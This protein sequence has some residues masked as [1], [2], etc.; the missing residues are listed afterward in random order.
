MPKEL[1]GR[2]EESKTITEI[3]DDARA[4]AGAVALVEGIIGTGKTSLLRWAEE[5]ARDRGMTVLS[6]TA[7]PAEQRFPLGVVHQLL[8]TLP[9]TADGWDRTFAAYGAP[10]GAGRAEPDY[11]LLAELCA[12]VGRA[13][14]RTPILLTVDSVQHVDCPSLLW[15]GFLSRR[16]E[17]LPVVLLATK[18]CGEPASDQHLLVEFMEGLRPDRHIHLSDLSPSAALDLA[19]S[20][21]GHGHGHEAVDALVAGTGGNPYLLTEQIRTGPTGRSGP[22]LPAGAGHLGGLPGLP[23]LPGR[24]GH[25]V[26]PGY[27]ASPGHPRAPRHLARPADSAEARAGRTPGDPPDERLGLQAVKERI[28]CML[29]R[30]DPYG[31]EIA[32]AASI[33]CGPVDAALLADL[34]GLPTEDACR[35]ISRLTESGLLCP[36]D[37]KFRHPLL[38][39]LLYQDIPCAERAEL[40]RLAARRMRHRGDPGED[41]AA[42]LLRSHRLDEPWMAQLLMEVAQGVVEH[43]PAGARRLVEKAVLHGVPEGHEDRA[44]TLRIQALSGLDLPAAARALTA[45]T[46]TVTAPAERFRHALLLSDLRLRL[47]DTAGA[48]EVLEEARRETAGTLD[49]TSAARLREAMAQVRFHDGG[50]PEAGGHGSGDHGAG[51][52]DDGGT[53]GDTGHHSRHGRHPGEEDRLLRVLLLRTAAGDSAAAAR[54]IADRLLSVPRAPYGSARWYQALLAQLWS[55]DAEEA[56]RHIDTEVGLARTDGSTTRIAEALA[57]RGLVQLHRGQLARAEDDAREA[58]DLLTRIRAGR[59]HVGPLA[60]SVLIDVAMERDDIAAAG[61]L[62]DAA[63]PLPGDRPVTWWRLHLLHSAG[64]ALGRLGEARRGLVLL[65]HCEEELA[66]RGIVNPAILPWRSTRAGLQLARRNVAAARRAAQEETALAH[67]WG[68]P[69]ALGRALVAESAA[70][71]GREALRLADRAVELLEPSPAPLLFAHALYAAGRA[72]RQSG[73]PRRSRELL[74]RANEVGISLGAEG[75][76]EAVQRELRDAGGRPD[77]R[78]DSTESLLTPTERQVSELAARG[79][80]NRDIARLL[81]V[82]LRNVESHLTH[83]YRKLRISGRHELARFFPADEPPDPAPVLLYQH[84]A[85]LTPTAN[86]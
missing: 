30:I 14:R 11:P 12:S 42:H 37:M 38:A 27:A 23:G 1:F 55:G 43:D 53:P 78:K 80:S 7:S 20:L 19:T 2:S 9:E 18:R 16:L 62:L 47:D 58:L 83:S 40:H 66:R 34:C 31:L 77:P 41:V 29:R 48:L 13:A 82:S 50:R 28:L 71:S 6:A 15:L 70:T 86:P 57:V 75:L 4:G 45:H 61:A 39:G 17:N 67:R 60:L 81:Q 63:P 52:P 44:E 36:H 22:L 84:R 46:S 25:P 33:L 35:C 56:R 3:L 74:H 5:T 76:V 10:H 21:C 64:R 68:A 72:H 24:S 49:P 8:G 32:R 65:A 26:S 69:F 79:L 85:A 51:S 59:F 54:R 73:T